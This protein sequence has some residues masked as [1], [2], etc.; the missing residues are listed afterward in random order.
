N[1]QLARHNNFSGRGFG[2][3][4]PKLIAKEISDNYSLALQDAVILKEQYE[5]DIRLDKKIDKLLQIVARKDKSKPNA[6]DQKAYQW[7]SWLMS[8]YVGGYFDQKNITRV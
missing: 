3:K 2:K 8:M 4:S 5:D 1:F 7:Y 6:K